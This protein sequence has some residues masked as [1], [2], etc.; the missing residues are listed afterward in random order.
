[1]KLSAIRRKAIRQYYTGGVSNSFQNLRVANH[2]PVASLSS[3]PWPAGFL[4]ATV[5]SFG[6]RRPG[7]LKR[8]RGGQQLE[9]MRESLS[10]S[11]S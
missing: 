11:E 2:P 1:M 8:D 3:F 5:S 7:L 4:I 10:A 6:G 9:A